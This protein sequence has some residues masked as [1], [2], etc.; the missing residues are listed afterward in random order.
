MASMAVVLL[1]RVALSLSATRGNNLRRVYTAV[2]VRR[3]VSS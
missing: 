2:R 1:L 3:L